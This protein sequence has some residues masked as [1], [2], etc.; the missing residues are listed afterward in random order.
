MSFGNVVTLTLYVGLLAIEVDDLR[1]PDCR[2]FRQ[3]NDEEAYRSADVVLSGTVLQINVVPWARVLRA[4]VRV[5]R[6]WKGEWALP[7]R[8]PYTD[9][10]VERF[11]DRRF[12]SDH[13]AVKDTKIFFLRKTGATTFLLNSTIVPIN[14]ETIDALDAIR[15]GERERLLFSYIAHC[16]FSVHSYFGENGRERERFCIDR[17][18]AAKAVR[19]HTGL[20]N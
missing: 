7:K 20:I 8:Q 10:V 13:I 1:K 9:I 12:C 5:R 18:C 16:S 4:I 6:L 14:L 11:D 3:S 2:Y 15:L 17:W 19:L